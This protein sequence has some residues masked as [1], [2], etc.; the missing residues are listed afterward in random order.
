MHLVICKTYTQVLKQHPQDFLKSFGLGSLTPFSGKILEV[1]AMKDQLDMKINFCFNLCASQSENNYFI[2]PVYPWLW[3]TCGC[4]LPTPL[5]TMQI[6]IASSPSTATATSTAKSRDQF[7]VIVPN[8]SPFV[9]KG[10][11]SGSVLSSSQHW[12][13]HP[14]SIPPV[15][16]GACGR[17][18]L[19]TGREKRTPWVLRLE[20]GCGLLKSGPFMT[21]NT[22]RVRVSGGLMPGC[23]RTRSTFSTKHRIV[24][25]LGCI[26]QMVSVTATQHC[27]CPARAVVENK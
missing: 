9:L 20:G 8:N 18:V 25:I 16:L 4:T 26:S 6:H 11:V 15:F 2:N 17:L 7:W 5:R 22:V 24:N 1:S 12:C 23:F 3:K 10:K 14:A 21:D 13:I 19:G 27:H